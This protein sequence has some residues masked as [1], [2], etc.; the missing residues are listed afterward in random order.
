MNT[1]EI[2]DPK[3]TP[4][5][6]P[7]HSAMEERLGVDRAQWATLVQ[8]IWPNA[9]TVE[10]VVLAINYCK[11]RNLDPFKRPIHIVPM[12][13]SIQKK[14]VETVWPGISEIR[15]T[16]HRTKQY[17]GSDEAKFGETIE[18]KIGK[19][20]MTYPEW[21]QHTV[22][23]ML[24]GVRCAFPGPRVYWR[25]TYAQAKRD[26]PSPN[27]MWAKRPFGQLDKCAEAAALRA[28]FPEE[29]GNE[30]T[31]DEMAGQTIGPEGAK[32]ITPETERPELSD[33]TEPATVYMFIEESGEVSSE[34]TSPNDYVDLL[35]RLME[36]DGVDFHAL[37][38]ANSTSIGLLADEDDGAF[39]AAV[40]ECYA[41]LCE[42][43][44]S[45]NQKTKSQSSAKAKA[46]AADKS[47]GDQEDH[48]GASKDEQ[49]GGDASA[50]VSENSSTSDAA[51]STDWDIVEA[52][53]LAD[54]AKCTDTATF[55]QEH[56]NTINDM[57]AADF[58]EKATAIQTAISDRRRELD[59]G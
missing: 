30:L 13:D 59:N 32:D 2:V 19:V 26:D 10:S 46:K 37:Y 1:T 22:Y 17:A 45:A 48:G 35:I 38:N 58:P 50:P 56:A 40:D 43:E 36:A 39:S 28:A 55:A 54:L 5:R 44:E 12:W 11:A 52:D 27:S 47:N 41:K 53:L 25:E 16:A 15:T 31:A 7:Y 24:D 14:M 21:C 57:R 20:G 6:L 29:I 51:A 8:V 4:P 34:F 3:L 42:A 49:S 9:K 33:F 18:A 23:R